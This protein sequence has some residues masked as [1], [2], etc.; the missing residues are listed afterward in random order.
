MTG[1]VVFHYLWFN[2]S[3][4]PSSLRIHILLQGEG[5]LEVQQPAAESGARLPQVYLAGFY[6][7]RRF[8]HRP[9]L[10]LELPTRRGTASI[11]PRWWRWYRAEA[12][13]QRWSGESGG[14]CHPLCPGP[15]HDGVALH[16]VPLQEE[17]HA[18][19]HTVLQEIHAGVGLRNWRSTPTVKTISVLKIPSK[20]EAIGR[21][22]GWHKWTACQLPSPIVSLWRWQ[23]F[24]FVWF[25]NSVWL[26]AAI[27][28]PRVLCW[29]E[30]V[31]Y[32][33]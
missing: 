24:V 4:L 17:G 10:G 9:R 11:W 23:C 12:G 5:V 28:L 33:P 31:L 21:S 27:L 7:L 2:M 1:L 30:L 22:E 8:A 32:K 19:P 13:E 18:A 20:V 16:R 6:G 26:W 15:V 29:S 3:C 25:W 14:H